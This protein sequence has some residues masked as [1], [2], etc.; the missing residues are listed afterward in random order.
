MI[1]ISDIEKC[2]HT[3]ELDIVALNKMSIEVNDGEFV[4]IMGHQAAANQPC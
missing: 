3:D 2:Y 1:K 4:A